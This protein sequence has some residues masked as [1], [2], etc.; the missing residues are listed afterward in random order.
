MRSTRELLSEF[1]TV[2]NR[3]GPGSVEAQ[4][5]VDEHRSN[6]E[7][8]ELAKL[9]ESLKAALTAPTLDSRDGIGCSN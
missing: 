9:S 5:F 8:V 7:F 3:H 6:Q 1:T 2:L 4:A